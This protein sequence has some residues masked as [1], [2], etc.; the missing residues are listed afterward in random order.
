MTIDGDEVTVWGKAAHCPIIYLHVFEGNGEDVWMRC[1]GLDCPPFSLVAVWVPDW[2]DAMSPWPC[3][4]IS[5]DGRSCG[6]HAAD[7]LAL[8][9]SRIMPKVEATVDTPPWSGVVGYSLAGLFA[10]WTPYATGAFARMASVSGSLWY[11]GF[12]DFAREHGFVRTP[13]RAY[14]SLGSKE[15]HAG[16]RLMRS[17]GE[18]TQS[19]YELYQEQSVETVFEKNPGNHFHEP[20]LRTA[21]GIAWLLR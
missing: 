19:L 5:G 4:S 7:Q 10:A 1:Q 17:V 2:D 21:R 20:D 8:L 6:G 13:D 16:N 18:T 14:L 15:A 12:L 11:P 9:T 3:E